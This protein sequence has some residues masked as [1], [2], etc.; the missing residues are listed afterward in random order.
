M[1][2]NIKTE[3]IFKKL[4][5]IL[6]WYSFLNILLFLVHVCLKLNYIFIIQD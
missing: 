3:F 2:V 1:F 6:G 5:I 4:F